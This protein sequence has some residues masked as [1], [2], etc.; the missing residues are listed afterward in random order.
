MI[1]CILQGGIIIRPNVI[2]DKHALYNVIPN[3]RH[4]LSFRTSIH[5]KLSFRRENPLTLSF[6]TENPL[7]LSFRTENPFTLSFRT[8]NPFTL[9][10]RTEQSE[11]E[12]SSS[13]IRFLAYARN[14]KG[15][16]LEMTERESK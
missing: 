8:E 2:L 4:T 9:S 5:T 13:R 3:N 11:C 15:W 1:L 12:E 6:R 16:M 10:F 14:D 7:I